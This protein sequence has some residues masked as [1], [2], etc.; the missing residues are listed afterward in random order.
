MSLI[1][2]VNLAERL[3]DQSPSHDSPRQSGAKLAPVKGGEDA[4]AAT[5]DHFTPSA[6]TD[7]DHATAQA[8]GLFRASQITFFSAAAD[9]LL[10]QTA[11]QTANPPAPAQALPT[12]APAAQAVSAVPPREPLIPLGPVATTAP[13]SPGAAAPTDA[14]SGGATNALASA[15]AA[16]GSNS[17]ASGLSQLQALNNALASLGLNA[18]QLAQVDHIASLIQD[19][20]PTAFL[21]LVHQLE[22][23]AQANSDQPAEANAANSAV[24][25]S[26]SPAPANAPATNNSNGAT[27]SGFQLRELVI[28]FSGAQETLTGGANGNGG[29]STLQLSAS[30]LQ[31]EEVNLTLTNN[32]G[33]TLQVQAPQPA[34]NAPDATSAGGTQTALKAI[35]ATG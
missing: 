5:Q 27:S 31:V 12:A 20:N 11:P 3:L 13:S 18:Q 26:N 34:A 6:A 8:A 32:A 7:Q 16:P 23:L 21:S 24:P 9:F 30:N 15:T 19:F 22:V 25:G 2:I 17:T 35:A 1:A 10:A 29:N 28:K 4:A 14:G 33:Q